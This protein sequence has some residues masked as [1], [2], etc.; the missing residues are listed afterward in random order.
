MQEGGITI[1]G[2][3]KPARAIGPGDRP[4][5]D[6]AFDESQYAQ[7]VATRYRT[8][9]HVDRVE[10]DDFDLIDALARLYDEPYADSSAIPT[11]RV[12]QLARTHVTVALSGDGGD[13]VFAG[14]NRHRLAR[15]LAGAMRLPRRLR[16]AAAALLRAPS[17]AGWDRLLGVLPRRLRPLTAQITGIGNAC[18]MRRKSKARA[19]RSSWRSMPQQCG[20]S[21]GASSSSSDSLVL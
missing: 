12:C 1:I 4:H 17:P 3:S 8:H 21:F 2:R 9:H 6:P 10:S 16:A 5:R 11:Y 13:E 19:R 15:Q 14:Y 20:T 18:V 7:L